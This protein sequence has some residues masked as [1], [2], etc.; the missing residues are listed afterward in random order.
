MEID[1][2]GGF[3]KGRSFAA[4]SQECMNLYP[5]IS[6]NSLSKS[7]MILIGTPGSELYVSFGNM[8]GS[9]LLYSSYSDRLF[10][11]I[12][13][14]LFEVFG[15]QTYVERGTFSSNFGVVTV[16]E[17]ETQ[18][19]FSD[20]RFG[21]IYNLNTNEL[22]KITSADY[23]IGTH[24][25]NIDRFF[26]QNETNSGKLIWSA[27]GDGTTWN[28]LDWATAEYTPDYIRAIVKL[29][30]EAVL[31][32]QK[33]TEFWYSTG[34]SAA[35]FKRIPNAFI[36]IGIGAIR[37]AAVLNNTMYWIGSNDQG[38]NTVW[39]ATNYIPKQISTH[40]IEYIL[41][42]VQDPGDAIGYCY[43]EEGHSFYVLSLQSGN[44]TLVYD[45]TTDLWH[46]RGLFNE[47]TG[48]NDM[49]RFCTRALWH[50]KNYV[51]D[52]IDGSIH[53]LDL[54]TYTD[55]GTP[56]QR[57]RTGGHVHGDRQRLFCAEFEID[58]QRGVGLQNGQGSDP[59]G[60]LRVSNNGGAT[61]SRGMLGTPGRVGKYQERLH[62]HRLG[63][64]RDF[65]FKFTTQEPVKWVL[66]GAR[67]DLR[68]AE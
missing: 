10:T 68:K 12:Y 24:V 49:Q 47:K 58:V 23:Q 30:N 57:I 21:Y 41:S 29:N 54:D 60:Y 3:N 52:I 34:D 48:L 2:I 39:A 26:I 5:E 6:D 63:M 20:G 66:L 28:A 65:V 51:G 19:M 64:S 22:E 55:N 7:R 38:N 61:W 1:F 36:N 4:D 46:E 67:A 42:H 18:L 43:Q 16:A 59:E 25:I 32:K 35:P 17:N 13:N 9:R 33:T 15:N 44:R 37:S 14:K 11:V 45:A 40:A 27:I 8:G 56:I 62:W 50:G 31:F 53:R